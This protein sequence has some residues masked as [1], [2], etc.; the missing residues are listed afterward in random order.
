[1]ALDKVAL[2]PISVMV[3]RRVLLPGGDCRYWTVVG[4]RLVGGTLPPR[5]DYVQPY[6]LQASGVVAEGQRRAIGEVDDPPR[7]DRSA[8]VDSY[9]HRASVMQ[10]GDPHVAS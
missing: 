6:P 2:I 1:M 8:V 4:H 9:H 7:N 5:F 3:F 10:V